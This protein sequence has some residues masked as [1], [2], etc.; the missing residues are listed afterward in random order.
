MTDAAIR[1]VTEVDDVS[2]SAWSELRARPPAAI[3]GSR[4]WVRAAL[5]TV[6][7]S[8][9]PHL[10]TVERGDRV[11][12]LLPLVVDAESRSARLV[13]ALHNDLLDVLVAPGEEEA[14]QLVLQ[15]LAA[16]GTRGWDVTLDLIDPAGVLVAADREHGVVRWTPQEAAP[17]VD[18]GAAWELAASNR[19]R[20]QWNRKL[21]RLNAERHVEVRWRTGA[22][23]TAGLEQFLRVRS[24]R[25]RATGRPQ[26]LPPVEMIE[27]V[28]PELARDGRCALVEL[29]LDGQMAAADLYLL[30]RPVA[31]MWLRALAV[32]WRPYPCGHLLLRETARQLR[33]AGYTDLDL[34]C[35][36]EPYKSVFGGS[37][38]ML[39]QGVI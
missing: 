18:L 35:G 4:E 7:R 19:R 32:E 13:A 34:G 22:G 2:A 24:E 21:R 5:E 27:A 33:A 6:D 1:V 14:A 3:N 15:E 9:R 37:R 17:V 20:S 16:M 30:D 12:A 36:G 28:V 39:L 38:R 29:L 23:V 8:W 10:V 25:L 26:D 11:V 31:L